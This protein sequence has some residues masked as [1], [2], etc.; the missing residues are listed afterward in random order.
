MRHTLIPSWLRFLMLVLLA[1]AILFRFSNI[2]SKVYSHDETYTSLRI[3]GYTVEEVKQKLFNGRVITSESFAQFQ[4]INQEKKLSDTIMSLAKEEPQRTPL[5]YIIARFWVGIFGNSVTAIRSLSAFIS[6]LV[7]PGIYW[8]C[9]ELFHVPLSVPILAIALA[10]V[11]PIYLIYATEAQ[12]YILWLVTI[13]LCSAS[14]IR[15][16][17]LEFKDKNE[18]SKRQQTPDRFTT[19]SLYTITLIISLYTCLWSGFVAVAHGV[20]VITTNKFQLTQTVRAYLLS[21]VVAFFA[22][23][24]WL[25]IVLA[26]YFQILLSNDDISTQ[27]LSQPLLPFLLKQFSKI[28]LDLDSASDPNLTYLISTLFLILVGCAIFFLCRTTNYQVWLFILTLIIIPA[29]P[30]VLPNL[31]AG[32]LKLDSEAYFLP[33]YLGIQI[34]VAYLLAT[35]IHNGSLARRRIWQVIMVM[36]IICGLVSSRVYY[37]AETWWHKGVSYNNAQVAQI[38]NRSARPLLIS[39]AVGINYGNVFSLSYLV[40]PRVRFKLLKNRNI[41]KISD[42]YTHVFFLNPHDTW[43]RQI[44]SRYQSKISLVY[45]NEYYS[46]WKLVKSRNSRQT[47]IL[48]RSEFSGS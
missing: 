2:D 38:I 28:F 25:M 15:A 18:L 7:F 22:C 42:N 12:E 14:L 29:M 13:I 33:A 39:D 34:A 48:R 24:P 41:P 36:L 47:V 10:A 30:L 43:R 46:L 37:Q 20:Y 5:Y 32:N 6:L 4:S 3:S 19:W 35:Q 11:S 26:K 21:S 27:L 44:A 1:M 16:I 9:R 45:R 23:I 17:R 40:Q 8:L 31:I